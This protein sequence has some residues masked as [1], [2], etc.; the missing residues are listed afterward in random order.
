MIKTAN[1]NRTKNKAIKTKVLIL[2]GEKTTEQ[3]AVK[4]INLKQIKT[5]KN[6]RKVDI[7]ILRKAKV[8]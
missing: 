1:A 2:S 5:L 8:I 3:A 7:Q 4:W 6:T